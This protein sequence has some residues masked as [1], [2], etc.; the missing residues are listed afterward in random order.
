MQVVG[1]PVG[2]AALK[3][4]AGQSRDF[5]KFLLQEARSASDHQATFTGADGTRW[6]LRLD[7]ATG[8]IDVQRAPG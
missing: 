7:L 5:L 4:L 8:D 6:S 1:D 3:D 2:V